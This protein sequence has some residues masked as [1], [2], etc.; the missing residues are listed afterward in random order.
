[1]MENYQTSNNIENYSNSKHLNDFKNGDIN[2]DIGIQEKII[3]KRND[4]QYIFFTVNKEINIILDGNSDKLT[5][6]FSMENLHNFIV[7]EKPQ[8][9]DEI[10]HE[11]LILLNKNLIKISLF[12]S[13]EKC[14]EFALKTLI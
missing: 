8:I 3:L 13:I 1:M 9:R 6:K 11:I 7:K 10:L 14:R 12:D 5:R 4:P 2:K